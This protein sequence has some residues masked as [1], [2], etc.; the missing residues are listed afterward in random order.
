MMQKLFSLRKKS[1]SSDLRA[2][3]SLER[4]GNEQIKRISQVV[5]RIHWTRTI[6]GIMWTA[7]PVTMLGLLGGFYL[8]YGKAPPVQTLLYFYT[9]ILFYLYCFVWS[10]RFFCQSSLR[11]DP[12]PCCRTG[13]T[14]C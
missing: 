7:G 6:L 14:R 2:R 8:A 3:V 9:F 4:E 12:W 11:H 10:Y 1:D 5:N 13:A